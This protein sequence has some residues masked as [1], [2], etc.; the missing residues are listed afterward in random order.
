[1]ITKAII[2]SHINFANRKGWLKFYKESADYYG[3]PVEV[4]LAKDSRESWLGSY[5][6]LISNGWYG[7]DGKSRGISQINQ[8][9]YPFAKHYDPNDVQA[10]VAKGAAILKNELKT[11]NGNL[12][13]ALAA[14]N[15][16]PENVKLALS[17]NEDPDLYTTKKNYSKDVLNRVQLIRSLSNENSIPITV[18]KSGFDGR[19]ILGGVALLAILAT[20]KKYGYV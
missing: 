3:V 20:A 14:Y 7:S 19:V 12:K 9:V 6:G 5:P 4:L 15:T 18:P 10:Y 1:L 16:G 11:F 13:N 17:R 8:D 2:Q